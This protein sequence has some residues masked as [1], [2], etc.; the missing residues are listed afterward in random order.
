MMSQRDFFYMTNQNDDWMFEGAL[1][2]FDTTTLNNSVG[3]SFCYY[4][5]DSK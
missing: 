4:K 5:P 3:V 2:E 1:P